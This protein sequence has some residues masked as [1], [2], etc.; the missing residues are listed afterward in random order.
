MADQQPLPLPPPTMFCSKP[1]QQRPQPT[2]ALHIYIQVPCQF[3]KYVGDQWETLTTNALI[4]LVSQEEQT[5]SIKNVEYSASTIFTHK[6]SELKWGQL[7]ALAYELDT[8]HEGGA[9]DKVY[10]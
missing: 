5:D 1:I 10:A 2:Q 7:A 4:Q 6:L 9:L 8:F 3:A